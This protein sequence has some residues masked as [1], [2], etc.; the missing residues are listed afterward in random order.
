M[1]SGR[2]QVIHPIWRRLGGARCK[3]RWEQPRTGDQTEVGSLSCFA[4]LRH[5]VFQK[6]KV[7][8]GQLGNE[9]IQPAAMNDSGTHLVCF[10]L[11]CL[12]LRNWGR[13]RKAECLPKKLDRTWSEIIYYW[14]NDIFCLSSS[15]CSGAPT[16]VLAEPEIS[17]ATRKFK[18]TLNAGWVVIG[19]NFK[20]Q[21]IEGKRY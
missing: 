9:H 12:D 14:L 15:V 17:V 3:T 11:L 2:W 16:E 13:E 1:A 21:N 5:H 6:A 18:D 10:L 19:Q 20:W 4:L 8:P 7:F